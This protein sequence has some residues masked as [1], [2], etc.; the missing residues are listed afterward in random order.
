M[1]G[2]FNILDGSEGSGMILRDDNGGVIFAAYCKIFQ[3]NEAL[4]VEVELQAMEE[5]GSLALSADGSFNISDGSEGSGMI[6]RDDNGGV[7]FAAYCKIFQCNEA[8]E[9]EV[10]LQAMEEVG[11]LVL[12][13]DGSFNISDGSEGSGMILRDDN[14]GVIFAAYCKIFQCNEALEVEVE[15][16]AM[17]EV[18]SLALSVD[19]S[20]NISDGSEGS[21]MILRDDNGGVIFAAYC[22]IFQCNEALEVEV[23]LQAMEEGL[24]LATEHS[25]STI[26]QSNCSL[27]LRVLSGDSFDR[28]AY[29]H[30]VRDIKSYLND[31][32]VIPVKISREQK[33][34]RFCDEL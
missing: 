30:L 3:C 2:S 15:L 27:A 18:G 17:E 33:S 19:G 5:V 6:L 25:S 28:S 10:E 4:E 22:K 16:Q 23:E 31:R 7:I 12:S 29:G 21:G 11:S 9:V 26:S 24:K 34:Y 20:F 14:G 8:L 32:V 13:V 1:D